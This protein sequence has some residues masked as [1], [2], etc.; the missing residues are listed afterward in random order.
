MPTKD[1]FDLDHPSPSL[2]STD[3]PEQQGVGQVGD[4]AVISSRTL[5]VSILAA[6][7]AA[8]GIATL[9][10]GNPMTLLSDVTA[11]LT[12][13]WTS[14]RGTDQSTPAIQ[15][16]ADAQ[17]IQPSSDA[18]ASAP[19]AND[20]PAHDAIAAPLEPTDQTRTENNEPPSGVLLRQFQA[21]ADNEDT[22]A[23]VGPVQ[24]VQ[25][26]PAT[27]AENVPAP[28]HPVQ[29]H[30]KARSAQNARAEIRH[31]QKPQ[32]GVRRNTRMEVRPERDARAQEQLVQNAQAPS[33]LQSLGLRQ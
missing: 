32:A 16:T 11:S 27:V 18:E 29:R 24:S 22:R 3:K 2:L 8:I 17:A 4:R 28:A 26:A 33:F 23:E 5:K 20:A 10:V 19:P 15:S 30:R 31:V 1:G 12:D 6:T 7:A 14:Q 25:D 13:S 9:S 21:W